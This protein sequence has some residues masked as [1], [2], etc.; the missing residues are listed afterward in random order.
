MNNFDI[1]DPDIENLAIKIA[2]VFSSKDKFLILDIETY[3]KI[4]K[5]Q[6]VYPSE[7]LVLDKTNKAKGKGE[8]SKIL[9]SVGEVAAMHSQKIGNAIR[10]IDTWY[11]DY[12]EHKAAIAIEPYGAVTTLGKAF[13]SPRDKKDFYS[14]FDRWVM[15]E[16]QFW[17]VVGYSAKG[18][19]RAKK[20][21]TVMI[22][23]N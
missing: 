15:G 11:P 13:R 16:W 12:D 7:E 14:V 23:F 4:G 22:D 2:E 10:T 17:C 8:K 1:T 6:D 19:I 3:V 18:A 20:A 9:Y 5:S 21:K